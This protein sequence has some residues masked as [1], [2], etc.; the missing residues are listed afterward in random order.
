MWAIFSNLLSTGQLHRMF[1]CSFSCLFFM[2]LDH[3]DYIRIRNN[4]VKKLYSHG[5]FSKGHMLFERLQSGIPSHL[6]GYV[7][8]VLRDLVKEELVLVYGKT[9]HGDAYQLNIEKL[10]EIE[11]MLFS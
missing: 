6:T 5:A 4:I 10:N 2:K 9:K 8:E 3:E 1:K 7:K 11:K